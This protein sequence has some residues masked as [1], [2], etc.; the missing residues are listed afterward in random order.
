MEPSPDDRP[1]QRA[2]TQE[3]GPWTDQ[4]AGEFQPY[5]PENN[6]GSIDGKQRSQIFGKFAALGIGKPTDQRAVLSDIL[7]REVSSRAGLSQVD[8]AKVL[9]DLTTRV[10]AKEAAEAAQAAAAE[11][12]AVAEATP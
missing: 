12:D 5:E 11:Q 10:E 3:P 8:A 1:A 7:H 9:E 2:R 4:A 6:P